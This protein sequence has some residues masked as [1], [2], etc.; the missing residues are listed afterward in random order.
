VEGERARE[1][2]RKRERET[3]K[4]RTKLHH[5]K[6][7]HVKIVSPTLT[8]LLLFTPRKLFSPFFQEENPYHSSYKL[9]IT[10]KAHSLPILI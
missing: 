3:E 6:K 1:R 5:V 2:E 4:E 10:R 8:T 7:H 9:L